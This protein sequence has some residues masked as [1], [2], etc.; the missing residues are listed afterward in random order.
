MRIDMWLQAAPVER[1]VEA[2]QALARE[3]YSTE[4]FQSDEALFV[5][6]RCS[7]SPKDASWSLL[8]DAIQDWLQ[9]PLS[10]SKVLLLHGHSGSG[11]SLYVL[12]HVVSTNICLQGPPQSAWPLTPILGPFAFIGVFV[13]GGGVAGGED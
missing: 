13:V 4:Q 10:Q 11:K 3:R 1:S 6:P 2:L 7:P 9:Q 12:L 5:A 8:Q